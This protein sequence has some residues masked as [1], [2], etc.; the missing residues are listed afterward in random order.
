MNALLKEITNHICYISATPIN[1]VD[2]EVTYRFEKERRPVKVDHMKIVMD[3]GSWPSSTLT[4]NAMLH[5]IYGNINYY[6]HIF[7]AS[8]LFAQ[9]IYD[10]LYGKYDCQLIRANQKDSEEYHKVLDYLDMSI[11]YEEEIYQEMHLNALKARELLYYVI[12]HYING[13]MVS[14][15]ES[16]ISKNY[17]NA[18]NDANRVKEDDNLYNCEYIYII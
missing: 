2:V 10:R 5:L 7:I 6:D 3:D 15:T 4:I 17:Y 16:V 12:N 18:Y 9:K 14:D 1:E 8:D 13:K 11:D